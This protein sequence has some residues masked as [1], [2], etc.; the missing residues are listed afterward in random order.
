MINLLP[1]FNRGIIRKINRINDMVQIFFCD[2]GTLADIEV[3]N[4]HSFFLEFSNFFQYPCTVIKK[5]M[6]K[7]KSLELLKEILY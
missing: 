7:S 1:G 5:S 4:H 2:F 3:R 6:Y